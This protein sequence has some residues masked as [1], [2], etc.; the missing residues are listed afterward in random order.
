MQKHGQALD[1]ITL[2]TG[3]MPYGELVCGKAV[4]SFIK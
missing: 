1:T 4:V 2:A 3:Q